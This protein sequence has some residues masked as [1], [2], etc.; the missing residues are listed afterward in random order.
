MHTDNENEAPAIVNQQLNNDMFTGKGVIADI[1]VKPI[2]AAPAPTPAPAPVAPVED[3]VPAETIPVTSTIKKKNKKNKR[4]SSAATNSNNTNTVIAQPAESVVESIE[5]M[6]EAANG[7]SKVAQ[8]IQQQNEKLAGVADSESEKEQ[9]LAALRSFIKVM[10][11]HKRKFM[12][13]PPG[14]PPRSNKK[15][16]RFYPNPDA[17]AV[18][19]AEEGNAVDELQ[20][21][22]R[23]RG[24]DCAQSGVATFVIPNSVSKPAVVASATAAVAEEEENDIS[25][26][27]MVVSNLSS[28]LDTFAD[29]ESPVVEALMSAASESA[30]VGVDEEMNVEA[31]KSEPVQ[32]TEPVVAAETGDVAQQKLGM[33]PSSFLRLRPTI[34][35]PITNGLRFSSARSFSSSDVEEEVDV[36]MG[37]DASG[38]IM[39]VTPGS[40]CPDEDDDINMSA[41]Q[42]PITIEMFQTISEEEIAAAVAESEES[43]AKRTKRESLSPLKSHNISIGQYQ[44]KKDYVEFAVQ[45]QKRSGQT[46]EMQRRYSDFQ[47]LH[48]LISSMIADQVHPLPPKQR[49]PFL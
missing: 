45:T 20:M 38:D 30:P 48:S 22:G 6:E 14:P 12:A 42:L 27:D 11:T 49:F 5:S 34:C 3:A 18:A 47:Q 25:N 23:K 8:V 15:N 28:K 4:K 10:D 2:F 32:E 1:V 31:V 33:S 7:L 36:R 43:E 13:L 46:Q 35:S 9:V 44:V 17:P 39:D 37:A 21:S 16:A 29:E 41:M 40:V 19:G 26:L 24:R